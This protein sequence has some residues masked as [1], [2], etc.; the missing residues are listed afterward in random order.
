[1]LEGWQGHRL[2]PVRAGES[3]GIAWQGSMSYGMRT[4]LSPLPA[5]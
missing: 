4:L 1:M 2:P 5:Q 3:Q